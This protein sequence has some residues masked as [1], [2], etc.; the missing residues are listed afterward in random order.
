[1]VR[2]LSIVLLV[3]CALVSEAAL[4]VVVEGADAE[5]PALG[6]AVTSSSSAAFKG[7]RGYEPLGFQC[8]GHHTSIL[9]LLL[10]KTATE[11]I[12]TPVLLDA[13]LAEVKETLKDVDI[14]VSGEPDKLYINPGRI[15][16]A[17]VA[18][19]HLNHLVHVVHIT[20][21]DDLHG[22]VVKQLMK[23]VKDRELD[24][25]PT[26]CPV[27]KSNV[28]CADFLV[29]SIARRPTECP[30]VTTG[31]LEITF[32]R[33][34][35]E[36]I[37]PAVLE[38]AVVAEA[39]E[40]LKEVDPKRI[41]AKEHRVELS[42]QK[43]VRVVR[44]SVQDDIHGDLVRKVA[45]EVAAHVL[46]PFPSTCP[47]E[48]ARVVCPEKG[49]EETRDVAGASYVKQI[50]STL[51]L[52]VSLPYPEEGYG[53]T[54]GVTLS[55]CVAACNDN[56]ACTAFQFSETLMECELKSGKIQV[57]RDDKPEGICVWAAYVAEQKP[58]K[59][60]LAP[61]IPEPISTESPV[62]KIIIHLDPEVAAQQ[63]EAQQTVQVHVQQPPQE[64][65]EE[66]QPSEANGDQKIFVHVE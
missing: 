63:E 8:P 51:E 49:T 35:K 62:Q 54:E 12:R 55:Q 58:T 50:C 25:F 14:T 4:P 39:H 3:S 2:C 53:S 13:V 21:D 47:V 33:T 56:I 6:S 16:V 31:V 20:L 15:H 27:R 22:L 45:V 44:L 11:E 65:G 52:G 1:M 17:E 38:D 26:T 57:H 42:M 23:A 46:N 59:A 41:S 5:K 61:V 36:R 24:P 40:I 48:K 66:A 43:V 64:A 18:D 37:H 32:N 30:S 60:P 19:H 10:N 7:E 28:L 9:E 34:Q 29:K